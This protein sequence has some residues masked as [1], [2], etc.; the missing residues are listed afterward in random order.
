MRREKFYYGIHMIEEKIEKLLY[1]FG[2]KLKNK[3]YS[4]ILIENVKQAFMSLL[5]IYD[6][7]G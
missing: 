5:S 2:I 3:G 4:I 6:D 1:N 7:N